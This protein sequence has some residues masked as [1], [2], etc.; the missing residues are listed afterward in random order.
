MAK[1][2]TSPARL[3]AGQKTLLS[4]TMHDIRYDAIHD[5]IV[6]PNPFGQAVLTFRGGA[7]GEEPP[8]R[9]IQG[10]SNQL[11]DVQRVDIDPVHNE[12]FVPSG[13]SI[14]VFRREAQGNVEPVRVIRPDNA[15]QREVTSV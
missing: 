15:R 8:I 13:G 1:E 5:E 11:E 12:I 14:L 7:S 3:I 2:N 10:P 4:R 6:V 9:I